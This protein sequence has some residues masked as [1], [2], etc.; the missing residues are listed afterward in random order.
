M[1]SHRN[2]IATS[3]VKAWFLVHTQSYWSRSGVGNSRWMIVVCHQQMCSHRNAIA[4]SSVKPW[5]WPFLLQHF[6]YCIGNRSLT[7]RESWTSFNFP[8]QSPSL[9][10]CRRCPND[11]TRICSHR[12]SGITRR[13]SGTVADCLKTVWTRLKGWPQPFL[14]QQLSTASGIDQQQIGK[15]EPVSTFPISPRVS[16]IV[17]DVLTILYDFVHTENRESLGDCQGLSQT[18]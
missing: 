16:T 9:Y 2:V 12:K 7:N 18:V 5:P 1:C 17:A 11:F 10:D 8:D 14:L 6:K 4:K 13:L 3:S 15:V